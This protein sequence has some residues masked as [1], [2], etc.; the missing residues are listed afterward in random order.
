MIQ[1]LGNIGDLI[2]GVGVFVT[3][4]YL[5][6]QVRQNTSSHR[7]ASIQQIISTSISISVS[8]STGPIPAI[9]AKCERRDR[10]TEEEF[11]QFLMYV[12]AA[13]TNHWQI[14]HQ[15]KNGMI[16]KEVL[17]TFMARLQGTLD[18]SVARAMWRNRI[19]HGFPADFQEYIQQEIERAG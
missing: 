10:L 18:M 1:N 16:D 17:D 9:F 3:L 19:R 7:L 5:A 15:Y 4:I 12:W 6:T 2:G 14:Y 13:L 8:A 11:A